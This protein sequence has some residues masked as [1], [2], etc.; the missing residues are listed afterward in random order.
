MDHQVKIRGFRIEL[1]EIESVLRKHPG[2]RDSVVVVREDRAN[3]KRL[4]AYVVRKSG[5][6][7]DAEELRRF[8]RQTLPEYMVPPAFVFLDALPLTPNGKVDRKAL[9]APEM[10]RR[11]AGAEFAEPGS[12]VE[13]QLVAIWREVLGVERVS[14]RDNFFELG[15]HSLLAIQVI[16]RV[17]EKLKVELP[18]FSLFDAPTIQQLARGLDSGEW[19]QN[20]LPLLP[21]QAAPRDGRLPLSSVQERLWFLDQ[22]SP[23]GHAY[24]VPAALRL[25]GALDMFAL[26]RAFDEVVGRHGALRT[27]FA[28]QK[29]ELVQVIGPATSME[30]GM[31]NLESF[32]AEE[33][34]TQAQSWLKTEVQQP[35]D[36]SRGPLIRV[37]LARLD[38][39]DHVLSVVMHHSISDG[40]SVTI[41][42]Q[43]LETFYRAFSAGKP[44]PELPALPVQYADF[45]H[46]QRQWMQG[47][48]LD[49]ELAYWKNKLGDAPG[50][51]NLPIDR[52]EPTVGASGKA[53]RFMETF[54]PATAEALNV[55]SHRENTTPFIVL[56]AALA[57]TFEKWAQQEDMVFGTVVAGRTR[58]EVESVIGC[59]MNFLPIRTQLRAED[60]GRELLAKVRTAVLE[61]QGHQDCPFEK[62]VEAVNPQRRLNQ[63]PLYNVALLLQNF[64]EQLFNADNIAI[65]PMSVDVEA[66]Q[67]DL[68][69]E[70]ELNGVVCRFCANTKPIYSNP[71]RSG[72][73]SRRIAVFS[74]RC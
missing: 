70:A 39:A 23:G 13:E 34:E 15:G 40:W 6:Q 32:P 59:F 38:A 46:W 26:Q 8:V 33:R 62:I 43:E 41:F 10:E 47:A 64:P 25:K 57:I 54:S 67:L 60:S 21:M 28:N 4:A 63:N 29:G 56:M 66:A 27:T 58:R 12:L 48:K 36:L 16:S 44:A 68:R 5:T 42:F 61:A 71:A 9:P 3:D 49:Q 7:T 65:T 30:I 72:K 51:V 35:F 17:R 11:D 24:N 20:Q 22:V 37:R 53:A 52:E 50:A 18:L 2:L 31:V 1:G 69:F 45:A 73:C 14:A 55:F 74:N 19:T